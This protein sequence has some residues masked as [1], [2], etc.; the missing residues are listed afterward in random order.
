MAARSN[1]FADVAVARSRHRGHEA[2]GGEEE[3]VVAPLTE[4]RRRERWR[5]RG[6]RGGK[7]EIGGIVMSRGE[8]RE[9][10]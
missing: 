5:R 9:E 6:A 10:P 8:G 1:L 4:G 3:R 2:W 7:K